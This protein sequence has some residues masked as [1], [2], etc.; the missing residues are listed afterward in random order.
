MSNGHNVV[1]VAF[2]EKSKAYQALSSLRAAD[3]DG[4][5]G[6]RSAVVVERLL[7]G[8]IRV[9]DGEDN[10]LGVGVAGGSLLGMLI[11]ALGGPVGVLLGLSTGVTVGALADVKRAGDAEDVLTLMAAAIPPGYNAVLAEI[12]EYAVE[13]LDGEMGALGGIV[14]RRTADDV[15]FE[16]ELAHDVADA[17]TDEARRVK[18]EAKKAEF[19]GKV[20][21]TKKDWDAR[22]S[23]LKDKLTPHGK[24]PA[25]R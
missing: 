10:I 25:A 19:R 17:V 13:V 3:R 21:E 9:P 20:E 7:D 23:A 12:D 11:G 5:I 8:S 6:V 18:R 2:D 22:V 4:R 24:A 14:F 16:L 15:L 1:A